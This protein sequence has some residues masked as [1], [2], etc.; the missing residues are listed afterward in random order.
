[1]P[2]LMTVKAFNLGDIFPFLFDNVSV[3]ICY[4]EVMAITSL[5]LLMPRTSLVV[6]VL[7]ASL[8]LVGRR[9][10]VLTTRYISGRN[11]SE[12]SPSKAFLLLFCKPV[13]LET[14]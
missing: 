9:L 5:A 12:L 2:L 3:S 11:V 6:L 1:M 7:L 8:A 14:L 4:K 13:L 10:L